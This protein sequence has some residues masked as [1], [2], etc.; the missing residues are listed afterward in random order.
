MATDSTTSHPPGFPTS[1]SGGGPPVGVN[2]P[3]STQSTVTA[4][5]AGASDAGTNLTVCMILDILESVDVNTLS[6]V[7]S[8]PGTGSNFTDVGIYD[9]LG[10]LLMHSGPVE[11]STIVET[12]G[13]F[14]FTMLGGPIALAP[15]RYIFA[16]TSNA[17]G[18]SGNAP[19]VFDIAEPLRIDNWVKSAD[20]TTGGELNATITPVFIFGLGSAIVGIDP[21]LPG[22]P[23]INLS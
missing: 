17:S 9:T 1:G 8:S 6:L 15:G 3:Q 12:A 23:V 2:I 16:M 22:Y 5:G 21:G 19:P 4:T 7:I 18:G 13:I 14:T 20:H 11:N 10:N